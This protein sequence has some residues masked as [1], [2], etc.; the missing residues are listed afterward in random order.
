M[1]NTDLPGVIAV[2][3][4]I[5]K[6]CWKTLVGSSDT[7]AIFKQVTMQQYTL[8]L[9]NHPWLTKHLYYELTI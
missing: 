9:Q 3:L 6:S 1:S 7:T 5:T 2:F 8:P 4:A